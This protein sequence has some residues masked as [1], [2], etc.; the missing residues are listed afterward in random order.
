[1]RYKKE[2]N[3]YEMAPHTTNY[4]DTMIMVAP[5]CPVNEGII[6]PRPGTVA[7]MQYEKLT[8]EPYSRTSDDLLFEVFAE[9]N[10]I[11]AAE[12]AA[13]RAAFFSRGQPCMRSSPLVKTYGWGVHHDMAG[14]V[15]IY[16]VDT[17]EY[18]NLV[19]R[20]D[21]TKLTGMRS[22]RLGK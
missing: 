6:P 18:R 13:A 19:G 11:A 10:G 2:Q 20:D 8:A 4:F 15:A 16:G 21:V 22:Q 3:R 1:L 9:R 7:A 12:Q 5:D 17:A 14:R